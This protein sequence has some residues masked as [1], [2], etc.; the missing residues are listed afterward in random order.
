[1]NVWLQWW[2]AEKKKKASKQA[3]LQL[4]KDE[5]EYGRTKACEPEDEEEYDDVSLDGLD[6]KVAHKAFDPEK[7]P[8]L[9][10]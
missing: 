2:T 9:D 4:A 1:M 8:K 3:L 10:V 6:Y 5:K 7:S